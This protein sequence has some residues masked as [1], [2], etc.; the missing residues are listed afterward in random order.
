MPPKHSF[1]GGLQHKK[2]PQYILAVSIQPQIM[3]RIE[4]MFTVP[5]CLFWQTQSLLY[6]RKERKGN[7]KHK[8]KH[9]ERK[10]ESLSLWLSNVK[11]GKGKINS[12][13]SPERQQQGEINWEGNHGPL[14]T[15][16]GADSKASSSPFP[17]PLPVRTP[18]CVIR[19]RLFQFVG[20]R[21]GW[22]KSSWEEKDYLV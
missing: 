16:A 22:A 4:G 3:F 8:T 13:P 7:Q 17:A 11:N 10:R 15:S 20:S 18:N 12:P 5:C 6:C 1:Q 21:H 14:R 9:R 2:P 19:Y